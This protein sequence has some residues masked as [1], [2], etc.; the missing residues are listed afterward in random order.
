MPESNTD[1]KPLNEDD[2]TR[3]AR[4]RLLRWDVRADRDR[5]D[6]ANG[7]LVD[8]IKALRAEVAELHARLDEEA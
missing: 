4:R 7:V 8:R 3:R 1:F 5:L 6:K 2:C